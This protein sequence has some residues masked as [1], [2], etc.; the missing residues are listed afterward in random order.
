MSGNEIE[1]RDCMSMDGF[2]ACIRMDI[3]KILGKG[4]KLEIKD[5]VKNNDVTLKGLII[6][7]EG[8]NVSPAIYLDFYY[9]QYVVGE[10]GMEDIEAEIIDIYQKCG[11]SGSMDISFM[12][13][14]KKV[15]DKIVFMLLSYKHNQKRLEDV[16]CVR[17]MDLALVPY[18][19]FKEE[20]FPRATILI[21]KAY[22]QEWGIDETE[23][24]A[25]A[26]ANT[27]KLLKPQIT[28]M[29]NFLKQIKHDVELDEDIRAAMERP[30]DLLY[31]LS[32]EDQVNGAACMVCM[33]V[34]KEFADKIGQDLYILP[35]SVY[36]VILLP[37]AAEKEADFLAEMV[38]EVNLTQV[39]P[40]EI[41]S[42][43]VY[44]YISASNQ[45]V[46]AKEGSAV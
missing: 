15:K 4:Y 5:V 31:I 42:F 17:W 6:S 34:L 25:T 7:R 45:V 30:G 38:R 40:E 2:A 12:Q 33:D 35:S 16:I 29:G 1:E 14:W 19:L 44:K 28:S 18:Y 13:D 37:T 20:H 23:L 46:I 26:M 10:T 11:P 32:G 27:P 36:E 22:L 21:K 43:S 24:L 3:Q 41:L 8:N 9:A 39:A